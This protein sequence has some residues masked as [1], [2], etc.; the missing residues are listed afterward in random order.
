MNGCDL[1]CI[2][3]VWDQRQTSPVIIRVWELKSHSVAYL[4]VLG[5]QYHFTLKLYSITEMTSLFC[6]RWLLGLSLFIRQGILFLYQLFYLLHF[7]SITVKAAIQI[8]DEVSK[9]RWV[10]LDVLSTASIWDF[11]KKID[12]LV[13]GLTIARDTDFAEQIV[14]ASCVSWEQ[15]CMSAV[16]KSRPFSYF[17]ETLFR[18]LGIRLPLTPFEMDLLN[19]V[20]VSLTQLHP[21]GWAFIR[22]FQIM[23][24]HLEVDIS[25]EKFFYFF[26]TKDGVTKRRRIILDRFCSWI[27]IRNQAGSRLVSTYT[28]SYKENFKRRFVLAG[29]SFYFAFDFVRAVTLRSVRRGVFGEISSGL[30]HID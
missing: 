5:I 15:V 23:C 1:A 25:G 26:Q 29:C 9:Y 24:K 4:N 6:F 14:V 12:D 22:G 28:D 3:E 27:Y 17:Y 11:E 18:T 16:E 2:E 19:V 13:S 30:P 10:K 8:V 7:W 20:Q 21:N